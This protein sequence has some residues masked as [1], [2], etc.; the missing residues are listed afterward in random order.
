[1]INYISLL[2]IEQALYSNSD[3]V[4]QN[5]LKDTTLIVFLGI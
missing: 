2:L 1:M 3:D 4:L 5:A